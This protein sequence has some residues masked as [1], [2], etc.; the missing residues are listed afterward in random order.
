MKFIKSI[1][2][3]LWIL[4]SQKKNGIQ[5]MPFSAWLIICTIK[6]ISILRHS[7]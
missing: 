5:K 4:F 1:Q 6:R 3:L 2:F 7:P